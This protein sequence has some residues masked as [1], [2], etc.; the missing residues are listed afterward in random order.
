SGSRH[1]SF[2]RDWSSD[3]CSS[4]LAE[5]AALLQTFL[6]GHPMLISISCAPMATQLRAALAICSGTE[7]AIWMARGSWSVVS[8]RRWLDLR[9]SEERREG[10][11]GSEARS[12]QLSG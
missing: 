9:S 3:V 4:D 12:G 1:T 7:P 2:S 10:E 6:A 8:T 5:P 11:E